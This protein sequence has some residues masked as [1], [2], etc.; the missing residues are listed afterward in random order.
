M[1]VVG[2][3]GCWMHFSWKVSAAFTLENAAAADSVARCTLP[4]ANEFNTLG[5]NTNITG[6][7]THRARD[8][9][10]IFHC[11]GVVFPN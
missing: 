4:V 7:S 3:L 6:K 5:I 1:W 9:F 2:L 11:A 10:Q 8:I